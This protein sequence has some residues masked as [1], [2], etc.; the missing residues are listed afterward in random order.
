M[1]NK[2]QFVG[3]LD[4]PSFLLWLSNR[5]DEGDIEVKRI[6]KTDEIEARHV[7]G[8]DATEYEYTGYKT[9]TIVYKEVRND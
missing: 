2:L 4:I 6:S 3:G 7:D 5:I 9:F 1:G 8:G